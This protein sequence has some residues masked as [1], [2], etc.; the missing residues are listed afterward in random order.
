MG[1]GLRELEREAAAMRGRADAKA[2]S[3]NAISSSLMISTWILFFVEDSMRMRDL[4][5][6]PL[7]PSN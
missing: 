5:L 3:R 7:S 2:A 1:T 4:I 6:P